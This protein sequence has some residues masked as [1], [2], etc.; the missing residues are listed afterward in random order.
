MY[1]VIGFLTWIVV[2]LF[3]CRFISNSS[4]KCTSLVDKELERRNKVKRQQ[5]R[6]YLKNRGDL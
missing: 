1:W 3:V 5:S 2:V 4:T 6:I